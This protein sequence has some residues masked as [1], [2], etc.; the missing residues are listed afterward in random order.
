MAF[1][2]KVTRILNFRLK[3]TFQQNHYVKDS[4]NSVARPV[5]TKPGKPNRFRNEKINLR[6]FKLV[7][8]PLLH[9][10]MLNTFSYR[11]NVLLKKF[12]D[13]AWIWPAKAQPV[14][15]LGTVERANLHVV[16]DEEKPGEFK[17]PDFRGNDKTHPQ[18]QKLLDEYEYKE[19]G[20]KMFEGANTQLW[21]VLHR[22]E[23]IDFSRIHER[24]F[25]KKVRKNNFSIFFPNFVFSAAAVPLFP[26]NPE[27]PINEYNNYY[28]MVENFKPALET[29]K[30]GSSVRLS[31]G[32]FHKGGIFAPRGAIYRPNR[33][34]W[35]RI[36]NYYKSPRTAT[37]MPYLIETAESMLKWMARFGP[38]TEAENFFFF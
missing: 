3:P 21:F 15:T 13:D 1:F 24:N 38:S 32:L 20:S 12:V 28:K 36:E 7:D 16:V 6:R 33:F 34:P 29:L 19:D 30:K 2:R 17:Y 9:V 22:L 26:E 37:S 18:V 27:A 35:S 25:E 10:P 4:V 14:D 23:K 8:I 5:R 31:I 11:Q